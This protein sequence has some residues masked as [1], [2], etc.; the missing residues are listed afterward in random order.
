MKRVLLAVLPILMV[1]LS[2]CTAH[3]TDPSM[4]FKA[5]K[6]VEE[7]PS[8]EE[9]QS[10]VANGSIYGQGGHPLFSDHKAIRVNDIVTVIISEQTQSSNQGTKALSKSDTSSLG[11]GVFTANGAN[12]AVSAYVNKLNGLTNIGVTDNSTS[13][14]SGQGS[15]TQAASF[16][17]TISARVIKVLQNGNYF[18][19][20]KRE[21]MINNEKQIVQVSGVIRPFDIGQNNT[22]N[23][24][25][26][27]DAK[28]LYKT[29]GDIDRATNQGWGAKL[30]QSV[31][32]F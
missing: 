4:N 12:P 7:M 31:W 23:S 19:M 2:G 6:Y 21:I 28:I 1:V 32:P 18:I 27:S 25:Q 16:T 5:P 26:I 10:Y 13:K 8:K 22:I 11:G 30:I 17:T 20:G 14:F 24:N 3:L 15:A 9:T 29:E